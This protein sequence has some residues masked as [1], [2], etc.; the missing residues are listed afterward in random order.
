MDPGELMFSIV[1]TTLVREGYQPLVNGERG[2]SFTMADPYFSTQLQ[3]DACGMG[4]TFLTWYGHL[5]LIYVL[6]YMLLHIPTMCTCRM[7]YNHT[8]IKAKGHRK[9]VYEWICTGHAAEKPTRRILTAAFPQSASLRWLGE[10]QYNFECI[11]LASN[12][13]DWWACVLQEQHNLIRIRGSAQSNGQ[14]H[15]S[16]WLFARPLFLLQSW[17]SLAQR[18]I[19]T[20]TFLP[21]MNG[22]IR[23]SYWLHFL[24]QGPYR[25]ILSLFV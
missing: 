8:M 25:S 24:V 1:I 4:D 6:R 9:V 12:A 17:K 23:Y 13:F 15:K 21:A 18:A 2:L 22:V 5:C 14:R 10:S 20:R 7:L 19:Y 11:Q 3:C 16:L